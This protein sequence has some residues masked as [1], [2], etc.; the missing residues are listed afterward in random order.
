MSDHCELRDGE[1]RDESA[2]ASDLA[3]ERSEQQLE[4]A[5]GERCPECTTELQGD[6]CP[7]CPE[8]GYS[9]CYGGQP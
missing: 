2:H 3:R 9:K 1:T 4:I 6:N 5:R 7:T 8:C